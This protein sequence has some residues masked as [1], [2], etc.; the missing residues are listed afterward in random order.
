M[1]KKIL[2]FI[3]VAILVVCGAYFWKTKNAPKPTKSNSNAEIVL[4]FSDTCPHCK[5]VDEFLQTNKVAEK[6]SFIQK[7]V[8]NN[9]EDSKE[10]FDKAEKCGMPTDSIG[11]PFLWDGQKCYSGQVEV[12]DFFKQKAGI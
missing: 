11:V 12:T 8:S 1:N 5:I 9:T 3:L 10:L 2:G 7:E 6:V 4:Y